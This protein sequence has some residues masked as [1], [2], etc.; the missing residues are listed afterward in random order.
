MMVRLPGSWV[1]LEKKIFGFLIMTRGQ[2]FAEGLLD[3]YLVVCR[4]WVVFF[5]RY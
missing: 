2:I 3:Y 4:R 5:Y 1:F